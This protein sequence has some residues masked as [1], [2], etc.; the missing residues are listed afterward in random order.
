MQVLG[1]QHPGRDHV[2][3]GDGDPRGTQRLGD[4][5]AGARRIPQDPWRNHTLSATQGDAAP[6]TDHA[7]SAGTSST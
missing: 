7:S 1:R 4:L 5:P 2:V 3:G 6:A